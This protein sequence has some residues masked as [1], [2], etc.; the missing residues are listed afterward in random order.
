[1]NRFI[2]AIKNLALPEIVALLQKEPKW[3]TWTEQDGKNGLHYLCGA[4]IA[5]HPQKADTSLEILK[6]LLQSGMDI[7]AVHQISDGGCSIFPATPLW[8]AYTRGR[9]EV[10]YTY[11]LKSGADPE[12]CMFAIAWY[13]DAGAAQLFKQYGA[14]IDSP[15]DP[16]SPLLAS[17]QWRKF[18]VAEWFLQNGANV[19][20]ADEKGNTALW[21]AVKKKYKEEQIGVLLRFGADI[22][23]ENTEGISPKRLAEMNHQKKILS[24]F[25]A[26]RK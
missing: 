24:L 5:K 15:L 21:Y 6:L 14:R 3:L 1:M 7:N 25:E 4:E 2:K 10:L 11:L 8:Y 16:Q 20:F 17:Y 19:D 13:D 9:N 18:N 22:G 26:T 12:H 23:K